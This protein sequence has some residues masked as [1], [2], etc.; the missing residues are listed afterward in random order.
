MTDV[1]PPFQT[2]PTTNDPYR[3]GMNAQSPFGLRPRRSL[4]LALS[5]VLL[6]VF[7]QQSVILYF[8]LWA[9]VT[10]E[11]PIHDELGFTVIAGTALVLFWFLIGP[12]SIIAAVIFA[13]IGAVRSP[14]SRKVGLML[15]VLAL[16]V[17]AAVTYFIF[18]M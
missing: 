15:V 18:I 10:E 7:V 16:G 3:R 6:I 1:T 9:A 14:G 5:G 13:I 17:A 8:A 4:F 12:L 11:S 2:R